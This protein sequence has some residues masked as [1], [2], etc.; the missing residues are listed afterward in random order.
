VGV[1]LIAFCSSVC[2]RRRSLRNGPFFPVTPICLTFSAVARDNL[3]RRGIKTAYMNPPDVA[4]EV[5]S[6]WR[7]TDQMRAYIRPCDGVTVLHARALMGLALL[8]LI[9]FAALGLLP[10]RFPGSEG[11]GQTSFAIK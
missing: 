9:T 6:L 4:I 8:N 2:H 3:L 11:A 10:S 7:G 1:I 5:S